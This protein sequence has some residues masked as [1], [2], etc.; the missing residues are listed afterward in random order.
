M[1]ASPVR[2]CFRVITV[3]LNTAISSSPRR[4][5]AQRRLSGDCEDLRR[6][7]LRCLPFMQ[8]HPGRT[9]SVPE[10]RKTRGEKGLLHL[11]EDLTAVREQGILALRFSGAVE[12][13]R[14]ISA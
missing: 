5:K 7:L 9:E 8:K 6:R 1:K 11:H 3:P 10:H 2:S 14:E 12:R 4:G 13:E